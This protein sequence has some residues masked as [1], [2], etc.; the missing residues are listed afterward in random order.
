MGLSSFRSRQP[1]ENE[2]LT[3]AKVIEKMTGCTYSPLPH[4]NV[5]ASNY[6][7]YCHLWTVRPSTVSLTASTSRVLGIHGAV[8]VLCHQL[9]WDGY[10]YL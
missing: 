4:A 7:D 1:A 3:T 6:S 8:V 5:Q 10:A 2:H 9:K